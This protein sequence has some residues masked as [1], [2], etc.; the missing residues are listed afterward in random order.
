MLEIR[1]R[2]GER[3]RLTNMKSNI[4]QSPR[5]ALCSKGNISL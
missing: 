5:V 3:N 1:E 4:L 2:D